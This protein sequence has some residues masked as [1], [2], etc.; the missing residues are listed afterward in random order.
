M[1]FLRWKAQSLQFHRHLTGPESVASRQGILP[2]FAKLEFVIA[3]CGGAVASMAKKRWLS[4]NSDMMTI[5]RLQE[6]RNEINAAFDQ[7]ELE[8]LGNDPVPVTGILSENV[9]LAEAT[10]DLHANF[11][12]LALAAMEEAAELAITVMT[13]AAGSQT[14]E[15]TTR[16]RRVGKECVRKCRS[17]GSPEP[18]TKKK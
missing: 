12:V 11:A 15:R 13:I 3:S 6:I 4:G 16:S 5:A 9:E 14:L 2:L 18:Y 17:G 1:T 8:I 7:L 10:Y